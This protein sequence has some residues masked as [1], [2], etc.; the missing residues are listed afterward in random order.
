MLTAQKILTLAQNEYLGL[1]EA[2]DELDTLRFHDE[3][4]DLSATIDSHFGVPGAWLSLSVKAIPTPC[5][6]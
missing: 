5:T 2:L 6:K 4:V 1:V 3:V